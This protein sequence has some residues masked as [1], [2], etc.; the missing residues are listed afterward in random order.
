MNHSEGTVKTRGRIGAVIELGAGF[1]RELTGIANVELYGAILGL[2]RKERHRRF[3]EILEFSELKEYIRMPVKYYSSG[4]VAR[5]AFAV[6]IC[7]DPDILLLDEVLSV[8][9]HSFKS[10]C[11]DRLRAFRA[12]GKTLIVTSHDF[13]QISELC[14]RAVWLDRGSIRMQGSPQEVFGAYH[15]V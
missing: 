5:L 9:D 11:S 12:R 2:T 6:A 13:L 8:G 14:T 7:S 1:H 4:M 3:G 15:Q 10:K